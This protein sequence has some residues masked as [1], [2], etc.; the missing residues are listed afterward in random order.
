VPPEAL[1][2]KIPSGFTGRSE[3]VDGRLLQ[4][5][6]RLFGGIAFLIT[7]VFYCVGQVL[8][9]LGQ[10]RR[11]TPAGQAGIFAI[12]VLMGGTW[13]YCRSGA[14]PERT[15][16]AIDVLLMLA[17]RTLVLVVPTGAIPERDLRGW[18]CS[19]RRT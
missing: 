5:R 15:L 2:P 10:E 16:R 11:P 18:S 3:S 6:L 13:L 8:A 7:A 14:R 1:L 17:I 9:W 12:L 4:E 19:C